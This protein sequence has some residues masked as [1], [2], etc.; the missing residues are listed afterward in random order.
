MQD[1]GERVPQDKEHALKTRTSSP[2]TSGKGDLHGPP[3]LL[4]LFKTICSQE[5]YPGLCK[6]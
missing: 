3:R 1:K 6:R 4:R 5:A 2:D